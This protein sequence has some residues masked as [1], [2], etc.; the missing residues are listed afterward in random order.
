M[1]NIHFDETIAAVAGLHSSP[2]PSPSR[3]ASPRGGGERLE[4]RQFRQMQ[5]AY[6]RTGGLVNGT[7]AARRL[8]RYCDQPLSTLARL[9]VARSIVCFEWRSQL[10]VPLFQFEVADMSLRSSVVQVMREFSSVLDDWECAWWFSQP[11]VWLHGEAPVDLIVQEP[12]R[13]LAAARTDR[14][15]ARG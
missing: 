13:V 4:D 5:E 15:V 6:G 9:I 10:L 3:A 14:F 8:R 11:N 12:T 7:E 2:S 1:G